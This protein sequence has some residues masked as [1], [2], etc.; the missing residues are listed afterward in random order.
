MSA[1]TGRFTREARSY[2]AAAIAAVARWTAL[3]GLASLAFM[4]PQVR[5]S[6]LA[7][8]PTDLLFGLAI[9]GWAIA[10]IVDPR[11]RVWH[12][13]CW[14][15]ALYLTALTASVVF[16]PEWSP[17]LVVKLASEFYLVL[18]PVAIA[19]LFR[20]ERAI[21]AGSRAWLVGL[22]IL[23]ALAAVAFAGAVVAPNS[24]WL[25]LVQHRLGSLS[26]GSLM[27]WRLGYENPNMLGAYLTVTLMILM[28]AIDRAWIERR[29]GLVAIGGLGVV[30]VA[31]FSAGIGGAMLAVAGWITLTR[32]TATWPPR[33]LVAGLAA[34]TAGFVAAQVVT[35]FPSPGAWTSWPVPYT[36]IT[37][38]PSSRWQ[39]WV[40]A[41]TTIRAHPWT[42]VGI[43][44]DVANV[45]FREPSGLLV[46][47]RDG[48]NVALNI[49]AGGGVFALIALLAILAGVVKVTRSGIRAGGDGLIRA[50]LGLGVLNVLIYQGIGGGYEEARFVWAALGLLLA[51]DSIARLS[52]P[53]PRSVARENPQLA[54]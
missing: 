7:V 35:P 33:L 21:V 41:W 53:P 22:A 19:G 15:F 45:Q 24:A 11:W 50:A 43:G 3:A 46:R 13:I 54:A 38:Y 42:G 27:R 9:G 44:N 49:A 8:L 37:L 1:R 26:L 16:A 17:R 47:L 14:A 40:D 30:M 12:P 39:T 18:I 10:A 5:V 25:G 4:R 29:T 34:G 28:L 2:G 6:G 51:S 31:T 48:H 23:L 32:P 52:Q 20:T 36:E